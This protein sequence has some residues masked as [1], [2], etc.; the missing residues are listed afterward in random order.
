MEKENQIT[1]NTEINNITGEQ[2][3]FEIVIWKSIWFPNLAN[4]HISLK[5]LLEE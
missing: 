5:L 2:N 1:N 3:L 4:Q